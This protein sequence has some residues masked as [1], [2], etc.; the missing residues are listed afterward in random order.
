MFVCRNSKISP[1]KNNCKNNYIV[2][3]TDV[4]KKRKRDK[5]EVFYY[6]FL[7]FKMVSPDTIIAK[8][9]F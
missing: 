7:Y 4:D 2:G 5:S 1:I 6:I 9:F 3:N 8:T